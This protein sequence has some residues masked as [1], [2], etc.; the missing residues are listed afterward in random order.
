[1]SSNTLTSYLIGEVNKTALK[2]SLRDAP[3][4]NKTKQKRAVERGLEKIDNEL[5]VASFIRFH[6]QTRNLLKQLF[7]A[8]KRKAAEDLKSHLDSDQI[9]DS[10]ESEL[11]SFEHSEI[12]DPTA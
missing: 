9:P 11:V 3:P 10:D 5:D 2:F 8:E 6:L 4:C 7:N 1:M 12:V